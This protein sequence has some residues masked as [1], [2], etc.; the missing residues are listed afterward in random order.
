M[1]EPLGT[2][3]RRLDIQGLRAV[4]VLAVLLYHAGLPVPGGFIGVDIFFVISGFVITAMLQREWTRTGRIALG[5]FYLRRFR[6]LMPA[7]ALTVAVTVPAALLV[8]S[9]LGPLQNTAA[10]GLGALLLSANLVTARTTGGYFDV[11]AD[12]NALLHTWSLSVE[13]QYYIVFPLALMAAWSLSRRLGGSRAVPLLLTGLVA[14][15]SFAL[16]L[17]G[18]RGLEV[19]GAESLLG[20][21][22]PL[23]RAWEFAAGALLVLLPPAALSA[24]RRFAG[25]LGVLAAAMVV[26]SL[27]LITEATPFPGPWTLLPVVGTALLL[28]CGQRA[29]PV[30]AVLSSAPLVRVGDWSYS[31]YL[32]HWPIITFAAL[33][34]PGSGWALAVAGAVSILPAVASYT[35]VEQPLRARGGSGRAQVIRLVAATVA[36]PI[37]ISGAVLVAGSQGFFS[38]E[39]RAFQADVSADHAGLAAGCDTMLGQQHRPAGSCTWNSD[40]AGDPIHLVG[41][42]NADHFSDGVILAAEDLGRPVTVSTTNA[43]PFL[44]GIEHERLY[45]TAPWNDACDAYSRDT[46]AYLRNSEPGVVVIS[47]TDGYWGDSGVELGAT[48]DTLTHEA[49]EKLQLL[50]GAF[51]ATVEALEQAGHQVLLV[52][53]VPTFGA[54]YSWRPDLCSLAQVKSGRCGVDMPRSFAEE[55]HRDVRQAL[56]DVGAQLDVTVYDPWPALCPDGVCSTQGDGLVR[57]M[58]ANH[59]TVAQS[60]ALSPELAAAIT[61]ASG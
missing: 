52:Q 2:A 44:I 29:T 18:L 34:W 30:G 11:S 37:A 10:T 47:L 5:R 7:L 56:A 57:Y 39:V 1:S 4:A 20:Y 25:L 26:A 19:L 38:P 24:T 36:A 42:S 22:S 45:E 14:V 41:D 12:T 17:L 46:L 60:R 6:R 49:D 35:F 16:A 27:W 55:R 61:A 59:L 21:Y 43:C 3:N 31:I 23:T 48:E 58:N 50:P 51:T 33:L 32:W 9:P 40:A 15:V 54:E 8:S 53:P 28:L 13:E